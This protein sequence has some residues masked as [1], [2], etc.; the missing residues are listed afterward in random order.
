MN[1][2]NLNGVWC[3]TGSDRNGKPIEF[4]GRVPGCVHTDLIQCGMIEKD[5][6][7]RDNADKVQWIENCDWRYS[8]EFVL[9][10]IPEA[11]VLV[12]EGLDTY[13]RVYLN[14][15]KLGDCENMFIPHEFDIRGKLRVGINEVTVEFDSPM[16][17]ATEFPQR[18]GAFTKERMNTRR[19]Q[20]TYGWDW[21][22]R[23]LTCGIYLPVYIKSVSEMCVD[24]V[25]V[26]TQW[27]DAVSAQLV[28]NASIANYSRG[29]MVEIR[30]KN[31]ES[32]VIHKH[33][34]YCREPEISHRIDVFSPQ[35]WYP[36][37]YGKQPMYTL[38]VSVGDILWSKKIGIR[39]VKVIQ[40]PDTPGDRFFEI[41]EELKKSPSSEHDF[42]EEHSGFVINVNDMSVFCQGANWV[43]CEP[44]PSE[45]TN[46]K[47]TQLLELSV[48][49]GVNT[50]RVWGGGL[51]ES[52]H[53]Y[54]ECDRLGLL[55][56]QD[57]MLACGTYPDH[58]EWFAKHI[59]DEATY[60]V[61]RLRNH[62]CLILWIGSN[63]N[64]GDGCDTNPDY[65]GRRTAVELQKPIV[66]KFDALR[67]YMEC[68]PYGGNH[69]SSKTCGTTHNTYF[70][71]KMFR[72]M[73]DGDATD[74]RDWYK[75]FKAR[76]IAEEPAFGAVSDV[77]LKRM[78]NECD[79]SSDEMWLYHS[80]GNPGL[81]KE[82]YFIY[83]DFA[84][85]LF[86]DF[87]TDTERRFK[88]K[89]LQYE[90][91]RL[92]MEQA[93]RGDGF[94]NGIIYWMLNDCWPA[95]AGW[96]L[97]DYYTLPKASFY[98]FKK[99]CK[100]IIGSLDEKNGKIV[101]YICSTDTVDNEVNVNILIADKK[102]GEIV[103]ECS[104][105]TFVP[106]GGSVML[107]EIAVDI[108]EN[109]VILETECKDI[110]SRTFYKDGNL[111]LKE[112][113][114]LLVVEQ[115]SDKITVKANGY[116]HSVEFEGMA[117]FEDNYFSLLPGE[118]R[119][120]AYR[121]H[122]EADSLVITVKAFTFNEINNR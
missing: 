88:L 5:I 64:S 58:E 50:V 26:F 55:V 13:C 28:I 105:Q 100:K 9:D 65:V 56:M 29:G 81:F 102:T 6:Y 122:G 78:M 66:A 80:K 24:D 42:N 16:R 103:S 86:G 35:L 76:F 106:A 8:R 34:V 51:F 121:K 96:A 95:A 23:F 41:C 97:L 20:C 84:K 118:E 72:Y 92:G 10:E 17:R 98:A 93:R 25:Y 43:P 107:G 57:F 22:S 117:V 61:K 32:E 73:E 46:E 70:L 49:A 2:I 21:V 37:G 38:E 44:F 111:G 90:I 63:E 89:Y 74:Y 59:K 48:E 18:Q 110:S 83:R 87:S 39:T 91:I 85:K 108:K 71:G 12:F 19:M 11:P 15:E 104:I 113:N 101:P 68:S 1:R 94:C 79:L 77:S 14:D 67:M 60:I 112:S 115:A 52:E 119:S 54:N 33:N 82:L 7:W 69:F 75:Q 114:E 99:Y 120:I 45:V 109:F 62:P 47:I 40:K 4:T 53:F 27:A 31:P 116:I 30:L 36:A 3:G